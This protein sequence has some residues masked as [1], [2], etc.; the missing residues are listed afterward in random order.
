MTAEPKT[1]KWFD[2]KMNLN[3][4]V[5]IIVVG[6]GAALAIG[7]WRAS[8]AY[9]QASQERAALET[10]EVRREIANLQATVAREIAVMKE[11]TSRMVQAARSDAQQ[12][13]REQEVR[14]SA[15][16]LGFGRIE[17]RL[18]AIQNT[19]QRGANP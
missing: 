6:V 9:M 7:E 12:S 13:Q 15:L 10:A 14:T 11:E 16:E 1:E 19:L 3:V 2:W 18:I 5:T 17:E 8:T 4:L